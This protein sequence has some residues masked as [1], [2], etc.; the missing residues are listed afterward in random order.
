M[1]G[2]G[3]EWFVAWRHLRDDQPKSR[4]TLW[5]GVVLLGVG[6]LLMAA[7]RVAPRFHG[8]L[9]ILLRNSPWFENLE[10]VGVAAV[11]VGLLALILGVLFAV[12]TVFTAFSMFG[13]LLGTGAP[14]IALSIMSGFELDLKSKIRATKADVVITRSDDQPFMDWRR[15]QA[16]TLALPG[17]AGAM[18]YLESEVIVKHVSNPAGMGILLRGIDAASAVRVLDLGRTLKEG[19]VDL[20][21]HPEK[22][23]TEPAYDPPSDEPAPPPSP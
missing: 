10:I 19:G 6:A 4:R 3:F 16:A 2:P 1:H 8:P 12:F 13:V 23:P 15:V 5:A 11:A 22:I 9:A 18:P 21:D 14:I 20:L 17:V 7:E